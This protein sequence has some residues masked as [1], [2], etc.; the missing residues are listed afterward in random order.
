M[1]KPEPTPERIERALRVLAFL[2]A[3][4]DYEPMSASEWLECAD[5]LS[6]PE[7][8]EESERWGRSPVAGV[9]A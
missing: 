6:R 4:E 5:G 3:I 9:P 2:E 8:D 7:P 1:S